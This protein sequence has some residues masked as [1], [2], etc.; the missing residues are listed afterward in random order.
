MRRV[1]VTGMG[2]V[3]PLGNDP[4]DVLRR[5]RRRAPRASAAPEAF[6][7]ERT[8][9]RIGAPVEFD[10][11]RHFPAPAAAHA[12]PREP[13]RA[14]GRGAGARATRGSRSTASTRRDRASSSAPAWAAPQTTDD[15]YHTLYERALRS[16]EAFQRADGD[17]QRGGLV[18][19][20]R[21]R[22][23]G[24][25][26][27]LFDRVLVIGRGHRRGGAAHRR[28]RGRRD[29]RGRRRG[30][31]HLRHAQGVGGAEDARA[32]RMRRSRRRRASR[33]RRIAAGWCWARARRWWCSR[34]VERA[35]ARGAHILARARRLRP[36]APTR[37]TSPG[38]RSRARRARCALALEDAGARSPPA[39]G[40]INAHGTGTQ[41]NDRGGDRR[42]QGG[43][44]RARARP[45]RS[46][47]PS[48]CTGIC[49][50]PPGRSSSWR[51]SSRCARAGASADDEPARARS[52]VR[53]RLRARTA[54]GGSSA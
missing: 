27:H 41:A 37:A 21:A 4:D 5:A 49:S 24:S 2:V 32:P 22:A 39:I 36:D 38:P 9:T 6:I 11:A 46:A 12:R 26:P 29:D 47:R 52:R 28:G 18:D 35:R 54:R 44:R 17:E 33:S 42:D 34:T 23:A 1:A 30:A 15:G 48:R 14:R 16:R 20:H 40:Y 19:R 43:L 51:R 50:A 31:A 3:S 10:G 53:P 45:R 7:R 13:A 25:E 8:V